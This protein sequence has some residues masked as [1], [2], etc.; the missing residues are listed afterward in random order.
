MICVDPV[1]MTSAGTEAIETPYNFNS[2]LL[3]TMQW[4]P[5]PPF[6]LTSS[7]LKESLVN[8]SSACG[9]GALPAVFL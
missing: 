2:S 3:A 6:G 1:M 7:D 4:V 5:S 9:D 8:V